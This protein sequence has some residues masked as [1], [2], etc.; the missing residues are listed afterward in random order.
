MRFRLGSTGMQA[1]YDLIGQHLS[2]ILR[3]LPARFVLKFG[4]VIV[5]IME[6]PSNV[7]THALSLSEV[8]HSIFPFA[9]MQPRLASIGESSSS[10]VIQFNRL[11][12][13]LYGLSVN[14]YVSIRYAPII[15]YAS[16]RRI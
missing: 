15:V 9:Q 10:V 3:H 16:I 6:R 5:I 11:A 1:A 8:L 7:A 2:D 14:P 4:D 13:T 12:I